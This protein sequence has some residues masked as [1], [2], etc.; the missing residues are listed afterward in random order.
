MAARDRDKLKKINE[1]LDAIKSRDEILRAA[2]IIYTETR[3]GITKDAVVG[4]IAERAGLAKSTVW[5]II[6]MRSVYEKKG[7]TTL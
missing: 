2:L 5:D 1:Q 4:E 3:P 6:T 7:I